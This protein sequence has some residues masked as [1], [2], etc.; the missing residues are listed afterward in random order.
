MSK[1]VTV[2]SPQ[3]YLYSFWYYCQC[4]ICSTTRLTTKPSEGSQAK[5]G[6]ILENYFFLLTFYHF[7]PQHDRSLAVLST[8]PL[9]T[10]LGSF[11]RAEKNREGGVGQRQ[12]NTWLNGHKGPGFKVW[13]LAFP[14]PSS[15]SLTLGGWGRQLIEVHCLLRAV[16]PGLR[17]KSRNT[18]SFPF[19]GGLSI[20]HPHSYLTF[21]PKKS[22]HTYAWAWSCKLSPTQ[23]IWHTPPS[24]HI[25]HHAYHT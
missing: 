2:K 17:P 23:Y 5:R 20:P 16:W 12:T 18:S 7:I 15:N 25:L 1:F 8:H 14:P 4:P 24:K 6:K 10:K 21:A 22:P 13:I 19:E 9:V 3:L 11:P